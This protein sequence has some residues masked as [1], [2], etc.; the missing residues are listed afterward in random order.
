MEQQVIKLRLSVKGT[1]STT[2]TDPSYFFGGLDPEETITIQVTPLANTSCDIEPVIVSCSANPCD[3]VTLSIEQVLPICLMP[4]TENVDLQIDVAGP[5][6]IGIWSG[7]GITDPSIGIFSPTL[8]GEGVHTISYNY[9]VINCTYTEEIQIKVGLPPIADA[10]LDAT[11]TCWENEQTALLGGSG[12]STG[13]NVLF[14]WT[15]QNGSLPDNNTILRPEVD[16]PGTYLLTVT[17]VELGCSDSDEVIVTSIQDFPIPTVSFTPSD[18]DGQNTTVIVEQVVGGT[19][20]YLFS[21][22]GEPYIEEDTFA[23]L[24]SGIYGLSVIDAIGCKTDTTFEVD[25]SLGSMEINLTANLVGRNAIEEGES[26]QLIAISNF[27]LAQF[28]S[29]VWSHPELLSCTNCLNPIAT[30][31]DETLFTV[32][33]YLNGCEVTDE[34]LIHVEFKSP[35]Y[36]PNA[37]SPNADGTND[38]FRIYPSPR[39]ANIKSIMIFDRWGEMVY[40]QH[41]YDPQDPKI[42]WDGK[43][44]GKYMNPA[45]FAWY[46][47][48]DLVDGS[49]EILKGSLNLLR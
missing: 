33:A 26:I 8:A 38:L 7:T 35:I 42:G 21:L 39:V 46:I 44:D 49:S 29:I 10:G 17:D 34:L 28:D 41:D 6:G 1:G 40:I 18:C 43:L 30:P 24:P 4:N 22:N 5:L 13:Q 47:E 45:V 14:E 15:T 25:Q 9:Q 2:I 31:I 16:V 37:F 48:V 23:F 27:S 20:P 19:E 36:V 32:T 3:D 11:L 12:T